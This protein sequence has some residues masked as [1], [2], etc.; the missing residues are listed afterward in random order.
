MIDRFRASYLLSINSKSRLS[1]LSPL[2]HSVIH[3]HFHATLLKLPE[4]PFLSSSPLANHKLHHHLG[5]INRTLRAPIPIKSSLT[6]PG[7]CRPKLYL[8]P[9]LTLSAFFQ[10][11][12]RLL[13]LDSQTVQRGGVGRCGAF[14]VLSNICQPETSK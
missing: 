13:Q 4:T 11:I 7:I 8:S 3:P 5:P 9:S 14:I 1:L 6:M 2:F 10:R 12:F